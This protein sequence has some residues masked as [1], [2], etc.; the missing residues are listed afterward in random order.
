M[1]LNSQGL[2]ELASFSPALAVVTVTVDSDMWFNV[3]AFLHIDKLSSKSYFCANRRD[4][5]EIF[6]I[7]P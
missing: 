6:F 3:S 4:L 2:V 7:F 1:L 5:R